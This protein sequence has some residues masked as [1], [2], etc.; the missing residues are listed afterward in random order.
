VKKTIKPE[1]LDF[2]AQGIEGSKVVQRVTVVRPDDLARLLLSDQDLN[3][4]ELADNK[5][6][7]APQER[8][9]C[10]KHNGTVYLPKL[11]DFGCLR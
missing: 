7:E 1:A 4:L 11:A 5:V 9:P 3:D 10:Q 2:L 6:P 8:V